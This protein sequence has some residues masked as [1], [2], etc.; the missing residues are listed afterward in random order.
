[1][2]KCH[3]VIE[4]TLEEIQR[5]MSLLHYVEDHVSHVG[6]DPRIV[7]KRSKADQQPKTE[8]PLPVPVIEKKHCRTC[9]TLYVPSQKQKSQFCSKPCYMKDWYDRHKKPVDKPVVHEIPVEKH[10]PSK[11]VKAVQRVE[12]VSKPTMQ[13][14]V[15]SPFTKESK[16]YIKDDLGGLY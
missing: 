9:G 16:K 2:F 10:V 8:L 6:P 15:R 14:P 7:V 11:V 3:V 4:G 13:K 12:K 5:V 1:M